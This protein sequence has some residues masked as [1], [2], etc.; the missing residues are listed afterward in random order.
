MEVIANGRRDLLEYAKSLP[1]EERATFEAR[2]S[3]AR[4]LDGVV[5]GDGVPTVAEQ[6]RALQQRRE[7]RVAGASDRSLQDPSVFQAA[8]HGAAAGA[9]VGLFAGVVHLYFTDLDAGA[10]FARK[11][12]P[13]L[14]RPVAV[15]AASLA[16]YRAAGVF[17]RSKFGPESLA[18]SALAGFAAGVAAGLV[19][20][21]H[22]LPAVG[23][24]LLAGGLLA[25]VRAAQSLAYTLHPPE[26]NLHGTAKEARRILREMAEDRRS[27]M[28]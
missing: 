12:A 6:L 2:L 25:G 24:G 14:A 16:A 22:P 17:A 11:A 26:R 27:R 15:A 21:R 13:V 4:V 5:D 8:L 23:Y 18:D 1:E 28:H 20:R 19:V 3:S 10:S 9:G 7:G